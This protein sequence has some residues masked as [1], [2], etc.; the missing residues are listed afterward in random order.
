MSAMLVLTLTSCTNKRELFEL[1]TQET[2]L[3]RDYDNV[4]E[5]FISYET[6][7]SASTALRTNY[8]AQLEL[9]HNDF[10]KGTIQG[11]IDL[12]E[13][14]DKIEYDFFLTRAKTSGY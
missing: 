2:I 12:L 8:D 3:K 13:K 9:T 4:Y 11:K 6:Y 14:I 10:D 1:Q 7:K 5:S